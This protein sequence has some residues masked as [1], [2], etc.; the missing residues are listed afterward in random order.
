MRYEYTIKI[1]DGGMWL[2]LK[3]GIKTKGDIKNLDVRYLEDGSIKL[4]FESENHDWDTYEVVDSIEGME[5]LKR[6][7]FCRECEYWLPHK[8]FGSDADFEVYHNYCA[9][10]LPDDHFYAFEKNADDFC[11]WAK[12]KEN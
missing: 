12:K 5:T 4:A 3:E 9:M 8:Q 1:E 6:V 11:S 10:H 2:E 7:I